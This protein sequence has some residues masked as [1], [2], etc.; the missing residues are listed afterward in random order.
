V[1]IDRE[2]IH[3]L[4]QAHHERRVVLAL[5]AAGHRLRRRGQLER[6][7]AQARVGRDLVAERG[8]AG[9]DVGVDE[10]REALAAPGSAWHSACSNTGLSL[11]KA[12][13]VKYTG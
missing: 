9:G 12:S 10:H 2:L 7:G 11:P 8:P 3:P 6:L 4:L 5:L 1:A 13:A